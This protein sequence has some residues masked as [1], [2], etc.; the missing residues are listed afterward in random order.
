VDDGGDSAWWPYLVVMVLAVVLIVLTLL[1]RAR[2][3][4]FGG[5]GPDQE[6]RD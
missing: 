6:E 2:M 5:S 1:F 4:P 3:F